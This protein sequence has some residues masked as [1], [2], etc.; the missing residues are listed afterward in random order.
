MTSGC[1]D[2]KAQFYFNLLLSH[3]ESENTAST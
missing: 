2:L 1:I 3:P